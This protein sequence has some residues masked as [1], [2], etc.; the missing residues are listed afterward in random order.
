MH[1]NSNRKKHESEAFSSSHVM[2]EKD[3]RHQNE[4]HKTTTKIN[5]FPLV[6][7]LSLGPYT[8]GA[9]AIAGPNVRALIRVNI[10]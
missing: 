2:D 6:D 4:S 1:P 5:Q 3:F 8:T 7:D 9:T 10:N